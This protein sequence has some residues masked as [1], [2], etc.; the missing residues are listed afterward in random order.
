M[1]SKPSFFIGLH[2]IVT[3]KKEWKQLL[4]YDIDRDEHF[5]QN[6]KRFVSQFSGQRKL[7]YILY[8][9]KHG[10]H[11][12]YLSPIT[13]EK[14]GKYFEIHKK[15]FKGYYSGHTIRMSR[16]KKEIQTLISY[17]N[18]FPAVY[19]L[20]TIYEKRFNIKFDKR[21]KMA[22]VYENYPSRNL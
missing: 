16:K 4:F 11:I 18:N 3:D 12:I 22:A 19:P 20:C 5:S 6:I 7:S 8:R 1:A 17:S 10:F 13:A 9:T 2:N 21:I 15:K 14:W